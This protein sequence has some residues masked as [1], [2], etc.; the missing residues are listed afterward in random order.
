[1]TDFPKVG[2][3]GVH[4]AANAEPYLHALPEEEQHHAMMMFFN[5]TQLNVFANEYAAAVN[6]VA[7][8]EELEQHLIA[9]PLGDELLQNQ[10]RHLLKMWREIAGRDAAMTVFHYDKTLRAVRGE[11]KNVPTIKSETDHARL[12][13]ADQSLRRSFPKLEDVR[14]AFAHRAETTVSLKEAR[15]HAVGGRKLTFG[16]M[17]GRVYTVTFRGEDRKVSLTVEAATNLANVTR[18]V[19]AAFPQL[20]GMLPP[21]A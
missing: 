5:L 2:T 6:L 3:A 9:H 10:N 7:H 14:N 17:E 15:T 21:A 12:R 1:M 11:M 8:V 19:Y 18:E 13:A 16:H 20:D 4:D